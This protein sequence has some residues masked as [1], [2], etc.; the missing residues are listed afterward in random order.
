MSAA[1]VLDPA[2]VQELVDSLDAECA[3]QLMD[4][5]LK[6]SPHLLT[7]IQQGVRDGN[8]DL[9][10]RAAHCALPQSPSSQAAAGKAKVLQS[11]AIR[12]C[13]TLCD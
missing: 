5:F 1:F 6:D 3:V 7:D 10:H 11:P 12:Q 4:A 2:T 9:V 8:G 13:P